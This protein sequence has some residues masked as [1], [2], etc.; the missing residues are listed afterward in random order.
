MMQIAS[1]AETR[2]GSVGGKERHKE[3]LVLFFVFVFFFFR[4]DKQP[5]KIR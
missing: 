5:N 2:D 3:A 4:T 1:P